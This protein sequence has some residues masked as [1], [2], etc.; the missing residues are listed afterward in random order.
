[1]SKPRKVSPNPSIPCHANADVE[2]EVKRQN[3]KKIEEL[4]SLVQFELAGHRCKLIALQG[5]KPKPVSIEVVLGHQQYRYALDEIVHFC[6]DGRWFA[7]CKD[8]PPVNRDSGPKHHNALDEKL[9]PHLTERESQI[10]QMVCHGLLTKQIADR[11][12]ISE[13]TVNTYIKAIFNKLGVRSR[14][15]MVYKCTGAAPHLKGGH[16]IEGHP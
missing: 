3:E 10:V 15:A 8:E 12:S 13:F 16:Q 1:M 14:A 4:E 6:L 5:S 9:F 11:L 2:S 7:L